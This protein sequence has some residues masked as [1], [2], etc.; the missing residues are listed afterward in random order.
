MRQKKQEEKRKRRLQKKVADQ[1]DP[2]TA[3]GFEDSGIE[4][5]EEPETRAEAEA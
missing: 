4:N 5:P 3:E 2:L 1:Q